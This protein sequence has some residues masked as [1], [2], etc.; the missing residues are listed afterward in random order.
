M[1]VFGGSLGNGSSNKVY[2]FH[3]V[4][5][6]WR[7]VAVSA[8]R[9]SPRYGQTQVTLDDRHVV[10][11]GGC[12]GPNMI[13]NDV[14]LLTL[15]D[16]PAAEWAWRELRVLNA[17]HQP[18]TMWSHS[19]CRVGNNV[20]LLGKCPPGTPSSSPSL[21]R[22][23]SPNEL[24]DGDQA[25]ASSSSGTLT[26]PRRRLITSRSLDEHVSF[27]LI[28][29]S[30][31]EPPQSP[32]T[33]ERKGVELH[34]ARSIPAIIVGEIPTLVVTKDEPIDVDQSPTSSATSTSTMSSPIALVESSLLPNQATAVT[35]SPPPVARRITNTLSAAAPYPSCRRNAHADRNRQLEMLRRAEEY[36]RQKS[37]VQRAQSAGA[38]QHHASSGMNSPPPVS[39]H[40]A[41]NDGV[42]DAHRARRHSSASSDQTS[43]PMCVY[44]LDLS[45]V[46]SDR[47]VGLQRIQ[48]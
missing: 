29:T 7:E 9:P 8:P 2:V 41:G 48:H 27:R 43:S 45:R 36:I 25:A 15:A 34:R 19:G 21:H 13:Y 39:M 40:E 42:V 31:Q 4:H 44:V 20:V 28:D 17:A 32:A 3:T 26:P 35:A 11:V 33:L 16:D 1:I 46:L 18:S 47:E 14:W 37:Q 24:Q 23:S 38:G 30:S 22:R 12:G 10:I 5:Q 6:T